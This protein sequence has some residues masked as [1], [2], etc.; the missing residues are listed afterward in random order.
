MNANVL[1]LN[2]FIFNA[3]AFNR[4]NQC[5]GLLINLSNGRFFVITNDRYPSSKISHLTSFL[6]LSF[7]HDRNCLGGQK[8]N[9]PPVN[10][11]PRNKKGASKKNRS[12]N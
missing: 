3:K 9:L 6:C 12:Q 2:I 11:L 4:L 8:G 7:A 10:P 5:L 1:G